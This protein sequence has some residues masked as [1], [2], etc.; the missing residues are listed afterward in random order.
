MAANVTALSSDMVLWGEQW[1]L[2]TNDNHALQL[3]EQY[4]SSS[5][6]EYQIRVDSSQPVQRQRSALFHE[7]VHAVNRSLL[8]G[9]NAISEQQTKILEAGLLQALRDNPEIRSF[10]F[11]TA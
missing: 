2:V 3:G 5:T 1:E 9:E 10:I 7:L 4:A 6:H 11:D 8:T